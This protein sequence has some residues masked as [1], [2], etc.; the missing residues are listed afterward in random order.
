MFDPASLVALSSAPGDRPWWRC[1]RRLAF[2]C[3][4]CAMTH[5]V[6]VEGE[7]AWAWNGSVDALTLHPSVLVTWE[8]AEEGKK[9]CHSYVTDGRIQFLGDST[10]ALAGQT[11]PLVPFADPFR[12]SRGEARC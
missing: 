10:H 2:R 11:V 7:K 8:F 1:G 3:P 9:V 12:L 4:G 5:V 6:I